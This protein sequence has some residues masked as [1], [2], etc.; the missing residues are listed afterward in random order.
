MREAEF[1]NSVYAILQTALLCIFALVFF[2]DERPLLF[3]PQMSRTAG[4][5]LCVIGLLLMFSAF[6]A[7]RGA[8]QIAP[9]PKRGAQLATTGVYRKLR[10]PIY[11]AI[12]L[13]VIGLSLRKPTVTIAATAAAVVVFLVIKVR[14]EERLLLARYPEYAEYRNRTWGLIPGLQR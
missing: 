6:A 13:L 4:S 3:P 5:V 12:L 9:E 11:T 2:L 10:H 1:A 7:I 8:V 14:F